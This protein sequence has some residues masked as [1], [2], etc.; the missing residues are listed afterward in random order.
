[1]PFFLVLRKQERRCFEKIARDAEQLFAFIGLN[2]HVGEQ[3]R[4]ASCLLSLLPLLGTA[5]TAIASF[6]RTLLIGDRDR[7][8]SHGHGHVP[9]HHTCCFT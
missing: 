7:D 9:Q 8:P 1:M 3:L 6:L 2:H 4:R 5:K